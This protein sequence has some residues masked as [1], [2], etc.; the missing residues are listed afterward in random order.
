[1]RGYMVNNQ[2]YNTTKLDTCQHYVAKNF[3]LFNKFKK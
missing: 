2:Y 1:M 3:F